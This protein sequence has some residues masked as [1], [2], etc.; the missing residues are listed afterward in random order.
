MKFAFVF[1]IVVVLVAT[2]KNCVNCTAHKLRDCCSFFLFLF[3][4]IALL[5]SLIIFN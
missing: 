5:I 2:E 3:L 4:F 1:V